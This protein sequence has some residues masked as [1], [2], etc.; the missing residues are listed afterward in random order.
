MRSLY[1]HLSDKSDRRN[2]QEVGNSDADLPCVPVS[3]LSSGKD[4]II[5]AYLLYGRGKDTCSDMAI[6]RAGFEGIV[7][8]LHELIRPYRKGLL[9]NCVRDPLSH[10]YHSD[11]DVPLLSGFFDPQGRLEGV[12]VEQ[13]QYRRYPS[14]L[15]SQWLSMDRETVLSA[16]GVRDLLDAYDDFHLSLPQRLCEGLSEGGK[17]FL[18]GT[19]DPIVGNPED[20]G[21]GI[22]V[23]GNDLLGALHPGDVLC[24]P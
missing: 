7:L 4:E 14:W 24:G 18:T 15:H 11:L 16:L 6:K 9:Q 12:F 22:P 20:V 8:H 23:D 2:P 3:R 1:F 5:L 10:A 13:T 21:L 17:H 19:D